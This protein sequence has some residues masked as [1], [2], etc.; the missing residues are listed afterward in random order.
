MLRGNSTEFQTSFIAYALTDAGGKFTFWGIPSGQKFMYWAISGMSGLNQ[1]VKIGTFNFQSEVNLNLGDCQISLSEVT[2]KIVL[3]N[4]DE[5]INQFDVNIQYFDENRFRGLSVGQPLPRS[6]PNEY[7][8]LIPNPDTYEVAAHRP[9]Y[10]AVRKVFEL[11]QGQKKSEID[12]WIPSGSASLSGKLVSRNPKEL[13]TSLMLKS[14]DQGIMMN[15]QPAADGSYKIGNLPAGD[16]IIGRAS[17]KSELKKLSLKAGENKNLDIEVDNTDNEYRGYLVVSVIT[18]DRL[19][20]A[21][22]KVWLEK[23]GK[24][25]YPHFDTDQSKSFAADPGE[26][27][28]H[29][30]YPGY[31][32]LTKKVQIRDKK[33]LNQQEILKPLVVIMT[34]Q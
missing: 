26:Y 16:Y 9:D 21:G 19:L 24:I 33:E 29:A 18:E 31:K 3:E 10:P 2:V 22:T 12:L 23:E 1:W 25:I 13:Q 5:K 32:T 17:R 30:E 28:L 20:L 14:I 4:P 7:I 11:S 34:N 27:T 6:E 15:I 8:F